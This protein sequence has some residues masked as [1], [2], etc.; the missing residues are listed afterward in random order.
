MRKNYKLIIGYDGTRYYGWEH[1]PNTDMTIQGKI[2]KVLEKMIGEPVEILA[3]GR[4]DAGVHA[5]GQVAN[6]FTESKIPGEKFCP[7]LNH[8]LPEDII[9]RSSAEVPAEFDSKHD[10]LG[11]HYLYRVY[12]C[13]VPSSIERN[14]SFFVR[15]DL[16]LEAMKK[17][18]SYLIGEHNFESFRS[19]HCDAPHA[20]RNISVIDIKEVPLINQA[21]PGRIIEIHVFGNAFCRH[22]VRIISGTLIDIG[23][24]RWPAEYMEQILAAENRQAA[25]ITAESQGLYL[26]EVFYP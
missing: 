25:G 6:F 17:A 21:V 9:I 13:S 4:T 5:W 2:E 22:M 12:N 16:D 20:W 3:A 8:R 23:H 18:A 10:S 1:Q 26:C 14:R 24:H 11:K 7:A 15:G 19:V